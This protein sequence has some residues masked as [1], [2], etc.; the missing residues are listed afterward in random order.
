MKSIIAN[1]SDKNH[2]YGR[3][4]IIRV[5]AKWL[6]FNIV[7]WLWTDVKY[8]VPTRFFAEGERFFVFEGKGKPSQIFGDLRGIDIWMPLWG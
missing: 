6:I 3:D 1:R 5:C 8:H 7:L 2:G 4:A